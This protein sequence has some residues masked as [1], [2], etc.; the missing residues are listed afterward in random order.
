M[1][2]WRKKFTVV[3]HSVRDLTLY[4]VRVFLTGKRGE[5]R[6][7]LRSRSHS[8]PRSRSRARSRP[9]RRR[10]LAVLIT[11]LKRARSRPR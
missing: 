9:R 4:N 7:R 11:D 1:G 2:K 10:V 3:T 8:R 5:P 6:R